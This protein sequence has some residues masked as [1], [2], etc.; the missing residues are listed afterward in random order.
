MR[1]TLDQ[2][3][4]LATEDDLITGEALRAAG[5]SRSVQARLVRDGVL[6]PFAPSLF[7]IC[8]PS[9]E[10]HLGAALRIAG[11]H[12]AAFG[13]TALALGGVG[14]RELPVHVIVRRDGQRHHRPWVRFHRSEGVD[15]KLLENLATPRVALEDSVV[16]ALG[17]LDENSAIALIT[18]VI[19]ER[20]TTAERLLAVVEKRRRIA[21]RA[22][23]VSILRDGAGIES[24]LEYVFV[25]RV[26]RAHGLVPMVRQYVVPET[27]HR[28]DGAHPDRRAL[29]HL[30]GARYH[31]PNADRELDSLHA[32]F[33]YTSSRFTWA[34]CWSKPCASAVRIA[35]GPP[36]KRCR[37]CPPG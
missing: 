15:R 1:I 37:R 5:M 27:G 36:P 32:G 9:W 21:H 17:T 4:S 6:H 28:A 35:G 12:S 22:V 25:D 3:G 24:A 10:A 8:P 7:T 34:D 30:D 18:R 31:D 16:D 26:E 2:L 13:L 23:V 29:F 14:E 20:R 33:G 11:P 19:Q